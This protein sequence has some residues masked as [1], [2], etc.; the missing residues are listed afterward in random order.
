MVA[1][2]ET[3]KKFSGKW[4]IDIDVKIPPQYKELFDIWNYL[5]EYKD[6]IEGNQNL[7]WYV[8]VPNHPNNH[9]HLI[10]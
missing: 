9:P 4:Y 7:I 10:L 5:K 2:I 8:D 1:K 6:N 3:F